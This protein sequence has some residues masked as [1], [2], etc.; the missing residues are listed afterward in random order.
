MTWMDSEGI[1]LGEMSDRKINTV[2]YHFNVESQKVDQ[3][4]NVTKKKQIHRYRLQIISYQWGQG[5][6]EGK[7]RVKE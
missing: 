3:N 6:G 1:M 2:W 7:D 5:W 4:S